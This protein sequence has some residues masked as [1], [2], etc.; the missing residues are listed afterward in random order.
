MRGQSCQDQREGRPIRD[1]AY[2]QVV[3][4]EGERVEEQPGHW[5]WMILEFGW[6]WGEGVGFRNCHYHDILMPMG[7]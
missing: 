5:L 2:A 3:Q 7:E 6:G 4:A 1:A